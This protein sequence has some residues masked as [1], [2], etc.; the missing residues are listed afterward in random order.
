MLLLL[1]LMLLAFDAFI[2]EQTNE[3]VQP[4]TRFLHLNEIVAYSVS[5]F[6]GMY[7]CVFVYVAVFYFIPSVCDYSFAVHSMYILEKR[8]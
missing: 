1:V 5:L 2:H 8:M 7:E 6:F 3:R 4:L